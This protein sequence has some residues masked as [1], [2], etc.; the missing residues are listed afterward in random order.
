MYSCKLS[1]NQGVCKCLTVIDFCFVYLV[2]TCDIFASA[3]LIIC[4]TVFMIAALEF[5]SRPIQLDSDPLIHLH[6]YVYIY[7][8]DQVYLLCEPPAPF[9]GL[10]TDYGGKSVQI[11]KIIAYALI[12]FFFLVHSSRIIDSLLLHIIFLHFTRHLLHLHFCCECVGRTPFH[13]AAKHGSADTLNILLNSPDS[14]INMQVMNA[15]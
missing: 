1:L 7:T 10:P 12:S 2:I 11:S 15:N 6:V 9:V 4:D 13:F 8:C 5:L 3:F 14:G